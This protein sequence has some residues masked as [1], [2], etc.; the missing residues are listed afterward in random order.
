MIA[1]CGQKAASGDGENSASGTAANM[2][3]PMV[4]CEAA[5]YPDFS[6]VGYPDDDAAA[7]QAFWLIAGTIAQI[8]YE[9]GGE[10]LC[11]R[12]AKDTG[13]EISGVYEIF[14]V[15]E[16]RGFT[17]SDGSAVTVRT[18]ASA[19]GS[20]LLTWTRGGYTFSLYSPVGT[21]EGLLPQFLETRAVEH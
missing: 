1:A 5:E 7:P 17:L 9:V 13:E 3:N 20:G 4:S 11:F 14:D 15:D 6:L 19:A 16:E 8:D 18:R 21:A 2:V 10:K 12:A